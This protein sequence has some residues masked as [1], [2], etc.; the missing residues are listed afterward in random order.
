VK[1]K[2]LVAAVLGLLLVAGVAE[3][4]KV[5]FGYAKTEIRRTT[6]DL[7]AETTGCINWSVGPCQR[8]SFHRVDCVAKLVGESGVRCGF[9][10]IARSPSHLY[11]VRIHHKRVFCS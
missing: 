3:A 5:P 10:M 6:A 7:C 2:V 9:V 1:T 4:H 11:E 8:K